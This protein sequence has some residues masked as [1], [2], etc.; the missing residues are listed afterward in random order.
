M[1]NLF[2]VITSLVLVKVA[3]LPV[4]AGIALLCCLLDLIDGEA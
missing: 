4:M 1:T 3:A 2:E